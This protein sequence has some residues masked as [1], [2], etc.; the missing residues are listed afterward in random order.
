MIAGMKP[1]P[2]PW[3]GCGPG[4]PP[5]RT[6]DRVGST[7]NTCR[8]GHAFFSTSAQ[9]VMWPPVPTPVISTSI[10]ASRKSARISCAVVRRWTS[11]LAGFS[12]CCGIQLS[13]RLG[14]QLLGALD[15]ALHALLARGEVEARAVGEHQPAPLE[16][17]ALGHDQDELVALDRGD[18]GEADAGIAQVGS[19]IVPPGFSLPERSASST[20]DS[21]IRSLIEAPG[22]ARS[23]LIHTSAVAE[24]A[25]DADVRRVADRLEDAGSLHLASPEIA[26]WNRTGLSRPAFQG[27][28][29]KCPEPISPARR[30]SRP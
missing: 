6:G 28:L 22:L 12:N 27:S 15:R 24:Q 29:D 2:M 20:I 19:M 4:W 23:C 30:R 25:V 18:H 8:L 10:G 7:A 14:D 21:A 13:G 1:A 26:V 16:A 9:A 17:H 5:E 11:R 3:I